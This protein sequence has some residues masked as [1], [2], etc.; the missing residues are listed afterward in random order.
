M[1]QTI[2]LDHAAATPTDPRVLAEMKPYFSEN[3]YNPS[4][5]YMAAKSVKADLDKARESV[6]F[7]LGTRP[8][9][10][11]FTAG[12]TEANNLALFGVAQNF[13]DSHI[14][15]SELEHESILNPL[16]RLE[17]TGNSHTL[18]SPNPD[19]VIAVDRITKAITEKTVLVS[20]MYAN[21]EIGTV[22]NIKKIS[23]EV[24]KIRKDRQKSGNKLPI[25]LHTD[26]CQAAAYLDLHVASIGVDMMTLNG[27]K[28]YGPK[29]SG[30]L[31]VSSQVKLNPQIFGGGQ[32]HGM[33]SGTE[34]V[35][36][37]IGFASA[38]NL[39]QSDR[40]SE[41]IRLQKLQSLFVNEL[42]KSIPGITINGSI[43]HRL[44]N[45]VHV[46]IPN[47]DNERLVFSLDEVG[48]QC[49]A[50]SAC[51]ASNDE[52]SHVLKSLGLSDITAQSS[53]RFSMGKQT[54]E[55]DVRNAV[56]A[57]AKIVAS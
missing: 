6:A 14:V 19:G 27:G 33:R 37:S 40:T 12:G 38:L 30:I 50:G 15:S 29:Q 42:T 41:R 44:P 16:N 20:I 7:W 46:T 4:A 32:E 10:I 2:Y 34:N 25:Y 22:Q 11:I 47:T 43:Q 1:K 35:A 39:V 54:T 21:N 13:P 31:F 26:A 18:V 17:N 52:P 57:L 36:G 48:V 24:A 9:N 56:L 55:T 8:G 45:N 53:L 51:S 28:I 3:F 5:T 49:A 23:A